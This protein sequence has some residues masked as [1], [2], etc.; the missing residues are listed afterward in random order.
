MIPVPLRDDLEWAAPAARACAGDAEDDAEDDARGLRKHRGARALPFPALRA[1]AL[2]LSLYAALAA[3]A[4]LCGAVQN[5]VGP[6]AQQR[7]R[8]TAMGHVAELPVRATPLPGRPH[9]PLAVF[10]PSPAVDWRATRAQSSPSSSSSPAL[11]VMLRWS[12]LYEPR[13]AKNPALTSSHVV[14]AR[15]VASPRGDGIARVGPLAVLDLGA[16]AAATLQ[17]DPER[18]PWDPCGLEDA[19]AVVVGGDRLVAVANGVCPASRTRQMAVVEIPLAAL[20][21]ATA[22]GAPEFGSVAPA[23]LTWLYT[24]ERK[25][26][27]VWQKNWMPFVPE[28][29]PGGRMLFVKSI[30][31]H[32]VVEC[33]A[34]GGGNGTCATVG[35]TSWRELPALLSA[36]AH[37][38]R[39]S[40]AV[41]DR[42]PALDYLA[43]GH[44]RKVTMA[45]LD[46]EAEARYWH[47]CY[48]FA[49]AA[50]Y[51]V[52]G[53]S[54]P[55]R[56]SEE[57]D[58]EF[59]S[60]IVALGEQYVMTYSLN[61]SSSHT[62]AMPRSK[63]DALVTQLR[64]R[65]DT[66]SYWN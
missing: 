15:Y 9:R 4:F 48:T 20:A 41:V 35:L 45:W 52:T 58:T 57:L 22:P 1:A 17:C 50:P 6:T 37:G 56:F 26:R 24:P 16:A 39:G 32:E 8:V 62:L 7:V 19:R 27:G 21:A 10:N 36:A 5:D 14:V 60:G 53:A 23:S 3:V 44:W 2:A 64:P 47:F 42:G 25:E 49:R 18:Y 12:G 29:T 13:S 11:F 43:C 34:L 54:R 63:L 55:F 40:T 59:L 65:A 46:I 30:E 31:P 61:D 33:D 28:G 66:A 38:L 51:A